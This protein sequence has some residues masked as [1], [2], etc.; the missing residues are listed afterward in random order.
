MRVKVMNSN[1]VS[2][3]SSLFKLNIQYVGHQL[4]KR[5]LSIH[6]REGVKVFDQMIKFISSDQ[7]KLLS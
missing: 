5:S 4:L 6:V 2:V 7:L 1:P 3:H